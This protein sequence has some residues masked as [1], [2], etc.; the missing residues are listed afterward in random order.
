[1]ICVL[2]VVLGPAKRHRYVLRQNDSFEIGRAADA[3][4]CISEDMKISRRHVLIGFKGD[5]FQVSDLGSSNGTF[6]NDARINRARIITGDVIRIGN[7]QL[8][9]TLLNDDSNPHAEDGIQFSSN[10]SSSAKRDAVPRVEPTVSVTE[11]PSKHQRMRVTLKE[12]ED[13]K[14]LMGSSR[15]SESDSWDQ[16]LRDLLDRHFIAAPAYNLYRL[17]RG[18]QSQWG[19]FAG[20][21]LGLTAKGYVLSVFNMAQLPPELIQGL[22]KRLELSQ[23]VHLT[24]TL[25]AG[26]LGTSDSDLKLVAASSQFDGVVCIGTQERIAPSELLPLVDSLVDPSEFR[27]QIKDPLTHLGRFLRQRRAWVLFEWSTSGPLGFFTPVDR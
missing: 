4:I 7:T 25:V 24:D 19:D 18:L 26:I 1:M 12:L 22:E 14:I 3:D 9:V 2:N 27:Q 13:S 15:S 10:D 16:F 23:L 21:L 5:G 6:V 8:Q 20:V 17:D 11:D